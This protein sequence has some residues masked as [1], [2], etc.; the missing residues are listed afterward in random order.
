MPEESDQPR[1]GR[2]VFFVE[3]EGL[4]GGGS[5]PGSAVSLPGSAVSAPGSAGHPAPA[6]AAPPFRFSRLGPRGTMPRIGIRRRVGVAMTR[7]PQRDGDVPSGYTYLGQFVDHDLTFDA[8][9]V[10]FG[11]VVSPA[12]LLQGRSPTLDLDS[13][14]G[15]GPH[16][17]SSRDFYRD[18]S[19]LKIGRTTRSGTDVARL[20]FD[21]PRAGVG[22]TADDRRRALIPDRR[23]D[24]NLAVAQ[25]HTAM[26]RFHN[27][28]VDT[29]SAD[30]PRA[31]RFRHARHRV[32][33]HYQWMLR[34]DLL[35]RICDPAVVDDVF[36]HGRRVFEVGADPFSMPTMPVEFSV[37]AYRLGHSM[38]RESYSW[39]ARFPSHGAPLS[40]LFT[41]SGTSGDLGG[42]PTLPSNWIADWRRLYDFTEAGRPDLAPPP[43][44]ANLARR[45]DPRIS[46]PLADLP[47]GAFAGTPADAGRLV[48]NLAF[49]NL[50][51]AG[52]VLLAS[53]QQ[54]AELL[55]FRGVEVA[56]LTAE[57]IM[58]GDGGPT[59]RTLSDAQRAAFTTR[60]PLWFYILR[61]AE[62]A[63][64]R[65]TGVGAR[66]VVETFH[67]AMEGSRHS[68]LRDPSFRPFLG[69]VP[70]R[71]TMPDLLLFAFEGKKSLLAP[72]G[73]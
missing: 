33:M 62:L 7:G 20:G 25:T 23:N 21:V 27:Q 37:G 36:E 4:V 29:L 1:H 38:V 43:G 64:G 73:D 18:E 54:M 66:I 44:Q 14:Y 2:D 63:G 58:A 41:F 50:T 71:F 30:V 28:A 26:I 10:T 15:A 53:G 61:E 9:T 69:D 31:L 40:L 70:G 3:G 68:I 48:G 42:L 51:R 60:T 6:R 45:I 72:L 35:P 34:H 65:L 22:A 39:N 59:L 46:D 52:M 19:H 5:P 16:D 57:E 67:R 17:E 56:T 8:T 12:D 11:D 55:R 32:T 47:P 24:E 13:L 49:R